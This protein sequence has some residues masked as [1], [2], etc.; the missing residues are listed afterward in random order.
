MSFVKIF[1]IS[2]HKNFMH[3]AERVDSFQK[4]ENISCKRNKKKGGMVVYE[5]I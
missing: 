2:V 3:N 5:T 1:R 4:E